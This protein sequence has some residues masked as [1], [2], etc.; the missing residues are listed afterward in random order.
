V[1]GAWYR[2]L[3]DAFDL[4]SLDSFRRTPL[5]IITYNYDR[6]IEYALVRALQERFGGTFENCAAALDSIG[7]I[8]LH[9]Q[10]GFLP[11]FTARAE[12][13]AQYGSAP[14]EHYRRGLPHRG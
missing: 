11:G 1:H 7:P 4:R 2:T 3:W 5:T 6:S 10:L 8:H 9:G 14:S 12:D 13:I